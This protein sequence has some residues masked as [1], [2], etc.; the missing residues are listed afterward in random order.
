MEL[1]T[2]DIEDRLSFASA[3]LQTA[4]GGTGYL[5]LNRCS[6]VQLPD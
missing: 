3:A 4:D 6:L 2:N 5:R 1:F